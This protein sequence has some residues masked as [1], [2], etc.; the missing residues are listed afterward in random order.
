MRREKR[1]RGL[2]WIDG[3]EMRESVSSKTIGWFDAD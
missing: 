2:D 1:L 3:G